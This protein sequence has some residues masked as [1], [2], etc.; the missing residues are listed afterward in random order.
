MRIDFVSIF[1]DLI[2]NWFHQGVVARAL[3]KKLL[4]FHYISPRQF[5][6]DRHGRV[7]DRPFGGGPGMVMRY[8]PLS[9][10]A[11]A[12]AA[13]AETTPFQ[14]YLSP[15]GN[16]FNHALAKGLAEKAHLVLWCGRYQ[17]L[18]QRFIE[19][20]I[21]A[22]I[23]VGD[24]ILSGGELAA[25]I[26]ADT[27][28]RLIPGVLGDTASASADSFCDKM[29]DHPHYTRPENTD[30]IRAPEILLSGDHARIARWRLKQALGKTFLHRPDLF[31]QLEL[32]DEQK[33][34]L[35][36]FLAEHQISG[37]PL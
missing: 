9:R 36:E 31:N 3:K 32:S 19:E 15:Q 33:I 35:N 6:N 34:L 23:S 30:R 5:S 26:V 24:F 27:V 1:P 28:C 29:L 4:A 7:D 22:E 12:I 37:G 25:A 17:G 11:R 16:S 8:E 2:A 14:I 10:T 18:D 13:E 20:T 21:D